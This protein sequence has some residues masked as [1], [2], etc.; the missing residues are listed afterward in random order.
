MVIPIRR[1]HL[2]PAA[3]ANHTDTSSPQAEMLILSPWGGQKCKLK[4]H[5][6][7]VFLCTSLFPEYPSRQ[8]ICNDILS[9]DVEEN[10]RNKIQWQ[11]WCFYVRRWCL[12]KPS[13]L[14]CNL[15]VIGCNRADNHPLSLGKMPCSNYVFC[16]VFKRLQSIISVI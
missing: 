4:L 14:Q 11:V 13:P 6:L 16:S 7:R 8:L 3:S 12:H 1:D 2:G 9:G 10:Y 5:F 15:C